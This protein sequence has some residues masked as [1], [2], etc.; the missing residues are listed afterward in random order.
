MFVPGRQV[1]G[2]PET[3]GRGGRRVSLR[4][5][6]PLSGGPPRRE[7]PRRNQEPTRGLGAGRWGQGARSE[8]GAVPRGRRIK[9]AK[10]AGSEPFGGRT[11]LCA[12]PFS[13]RPALSRFDGPPL[14][15][16]PCLSRFLWPPQDSR[17]L[18]WWA[19]GVLP[20]FLQARP[21]GRLANAPRATKA[22]GGAGRAGWE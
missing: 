5:A 6:S 22:F 7:F 12:K 16:P 2:A 4:L 15:C 13:D 21:A 3:R 11:L 10:E 20:P 9:T 8:R 19:P 14:P 1:S 17:D 18:V